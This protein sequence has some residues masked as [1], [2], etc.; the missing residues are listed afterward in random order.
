M[1]SQSCIRVANQEDLCRIVEI[2]NAS[3]NDGM[4][5]ADTSAVSVESRQAWYDAHHSR[6]PLWVYQCP[7]SYD[8]LG[9]LSFRDFYGRP[10]YAQ[11]VEVALYVCPNA[12][13][14]G[15]AAE[16]LTNAIRQAPKLNIETILAFIFAHNR[17]SVR[18]FTKYHFQ[19]WG[20]YPEV[21]NMPQGKRDL[22]VYG[23][24]VKAH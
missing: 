1:N 2:Y 9:W 24:A 21:A 18:L 11:T 13:G 15:I 22:C 7:T 16:L 20:R 6:R 19:Q 5:T 12:Q 10:A 4:A 14:K 8:V 23:L 17:P 3:I